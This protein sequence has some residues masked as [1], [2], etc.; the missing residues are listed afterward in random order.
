MAVELYEE[1][2]RLQNQIGSVDRA[3][4][5]LLAGYISK[6]V[7]ASGSPHAEQSAEAISAAIEHLSNGS[8]RLA[9]ERIGWASLA[10]RGGDVRIGRD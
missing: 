4:L 6:R 3:E 5:I 2:N 7:Q 8:D 1:L 10:L 9:R